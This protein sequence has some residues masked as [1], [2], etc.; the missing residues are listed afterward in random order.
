MPLKLELFTINSCSTSPRF[1]FESRENLL[2]HQGMRSFLLFSSP[3]CLK[4]DLYCKEK[5]YA[6]HSTH[7]HSE[8]RLL[9]CIAC[10]TRRRLAR[11]HH[12]TLLQYCGPQYRRHKNLAPVS[13]AVAVMEGPR[14]PD[15]SQLG[16]CR[17][18]AFQAPSTWK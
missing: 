5:L 9:S 8:R 6:D 2:L 17:C 7:L 16:L 13:R 18:M 11:F 3:Y 14:V 15:L 10:Y 1:F 4:K 12:R